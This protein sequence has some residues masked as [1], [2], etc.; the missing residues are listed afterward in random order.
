MPQ[1]VFLGLLA[2]GGY[3][4]WKALKKEMARVDN[5]VREAEKVRAED[6][7]ETLELD[8]A[9]GRYRPRERE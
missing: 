2:V 3:V 7:G 5:K 6:R 1:L 4:A 9:T 8:R